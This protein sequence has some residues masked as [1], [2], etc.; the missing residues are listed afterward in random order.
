M[1]PL[2]IRDGERASEP[3]TSPITHRALDGRTDGRTDYVDGGKTKKEEE[4]PLCS[5]AKTPHSLCAYARSLPI[6][7]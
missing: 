1:S 3:Y 6:F 7:P 5:A 2:N 4:Q